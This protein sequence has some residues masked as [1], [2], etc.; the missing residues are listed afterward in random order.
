MPWLGLPVQ[1][2]IEVVREVIFD[3]LLI[4]EEKFSFFYHSMCCQL[5]VFCRC[6]FSDREGALSLVCYH[7]SVLDFAKCC[8]CICW[9]DPMG[10]PLLCWYAV[11]AIHWF[12]CVECTL[13]LNPTTLLDIL[14]SPS[15]Y[16]FRL[17]IKRF[18]HLWIKEVILHL[19]NLEVFFIFFKIFL[20]VFLKKFIWLALLH[21][22]QHY[23]IVLTVDIFALFMH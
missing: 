16:F 4:L 18:S 22:C 3:L 12:S 20:E 7:E 21:G 19:F 11:L 14:V 5:W 15:N 6:S 17:S 23:C 2:C 9:D 8:F 1:S 10:C 13:V